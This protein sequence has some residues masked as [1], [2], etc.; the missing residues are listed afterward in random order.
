MLRLHKFVCFIVIEAVLFDENTY[1]WKLYLMYARGFNIDKT[2]HSSRAARRLAVVFLD[3]YWF[4]HRIYF[5]YD[6]QLKLYWTFN[7]F[8]T[9]Q[10]DEEKKIDWSSVTVEISVNDAPCLLMSRHVCRQINY[11]KI[12]WEQRKKKNS[13]ECLIATF[14]E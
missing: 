8:I 4:S 9:I 7:I 12:T 11:Y 1:E 3:Q 13:A 6:V 2:I 10:C 14:E 5:P